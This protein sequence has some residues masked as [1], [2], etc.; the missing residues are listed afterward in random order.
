MREKGH[1]GI[2]NSL[3]LQIGLTLT[4]ILDPSENRTKSPWLLTLLEMIR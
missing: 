1:N 3:L 4:H 2:H